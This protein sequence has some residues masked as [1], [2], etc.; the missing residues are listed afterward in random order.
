MDGLR[1]WWAAENYRRGFIPLAQAIS[2]MQNKKRRSKFVQHHLIC[3]AVSLDSKTGL[4][5]ANQR[6]SRW[7]VCLYDGALLLGT[8]IKMIDFDTSTSAFY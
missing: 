6:F 8:Q 1:K 4:I 5:W 3:S 7:E 2:N